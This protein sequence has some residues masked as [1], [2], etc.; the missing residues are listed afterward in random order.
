MTEITLRSNMK[1]EKINALLTFLKSWDD[2][3]QV[4]INSDT[5][6]KKKRP[7]DY[8]GKLSKESA[9]EMKEYIN[10]SRNEWERN[11]L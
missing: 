11:I 10:K 4:T 7:S 2:K 6:Y 1:K 3:I 5:L 8:F 9:K